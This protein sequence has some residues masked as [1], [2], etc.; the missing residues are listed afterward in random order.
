MLDP[1]ERGIVGQQNIVVSAGM[2]PSCYGDTCAFRFLIVQGI[3]MVFCL[4]SLRN[5]VSVILSSSRQPRSPLPITSQPSGNLQPHLREGWRAPRHEAPT[6]S[7]CNAWPERH[8]H[9]R[10]VFV[11]CRQLPGSVLRLSQQRR[12]HSPV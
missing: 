4:I 12:G 11:W 7:P 10:Q 6:T 3:G 5:H 1:T 8:V 9:L 2:W